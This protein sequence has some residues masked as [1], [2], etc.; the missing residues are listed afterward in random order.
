MYQQRCR[1]GYALSCPSMHTPRQC[2]QQT[3]KPGF[4]LAEQCLAA[5]ELPL[6]AWSDPETVSSLM[7][8]LHH[9]VEKRGF[10]GWLTGHLEQLSMTLELAPQLGR[11]PAFPIVREKAAQIVQCSK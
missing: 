5:G 4:V 2:P 7:A 9:Q 3:F 1:C 11:E 10:R 8:R 6:V